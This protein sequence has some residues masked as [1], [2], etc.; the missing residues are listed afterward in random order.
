[1]FGE[2]KILKVKETFREELN[3]FRRL[4]FRTNNF[5]EVTIP[6]RYLLICLY[7]RAYSCGIAVAMIVAC[8]HTL[9]QKNFRG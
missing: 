9:K 8:R 6:A 2:G 1:M 7:F 5:L 3:K 4:E